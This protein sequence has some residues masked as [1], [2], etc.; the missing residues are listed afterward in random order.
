MLMELTES[1]SQTGPG[2]VTITTGAQDALLNIDGKWRTQ[3]VM[4][5]AL[6]AGPKRRA[7]DGFRRSQLRNSHEP[8]SA[9]RF[10]YL[11]VG[12]IPLSPKGRVKRMQMACK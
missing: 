6:T 5:R 1:F 3:K 9:D 12:P 7:V 4:K 11:V 2:L 8:G 10:T